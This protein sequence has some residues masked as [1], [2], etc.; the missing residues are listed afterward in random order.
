MNFIKKYWI[1]IAIVFV[2]SMFI[3][4]ALCFLILG[5]IISYI[6]IEAILFLRAIRKRGVACTGN[7]IEYQSDNDGHKTPL[8]EFTTMTGESIKAQPYVYASTDL[9]KI[10]IYKNMINQTV[11]ILYDPGSPKKFVLAGEREFSYVIFFILILAGLVFVG[12]SISSI[13]GYIKL[14]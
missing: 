8:V 5:S 6:G 3:K 10:R 4:P 9:S 1:V 13:L 7:I 11:P 14:G 12:L 2:L